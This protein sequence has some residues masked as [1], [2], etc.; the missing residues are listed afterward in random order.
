MTDDEF[1]R[2]LDF[3]RV[4]PHVQAHSLVQID[5]TLRGVE[6]LLNVV[7]RLGGVVSALPRL[8]DD[9][10]GVLEPRL[11]EMCGQLKSTIESM[12]PELTKTEGE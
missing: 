10:R 6:A 2:I 5:K 9:I 12:P 4:L 7:H 3:E 11:E 1:R 8:P